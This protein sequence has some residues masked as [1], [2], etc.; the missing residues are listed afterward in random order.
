M[1]RRFGQGCPLYESG[2]EEGQLWTAQ[3]SAM[4]WWFWQRRRPAGSVLT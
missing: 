3:D 2:H 1:Y 4:D